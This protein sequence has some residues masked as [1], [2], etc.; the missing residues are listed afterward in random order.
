MRFNTK[1]AA[2]FDQVKAG[3]WL[4]LN[5]LPARHGVPVKAIF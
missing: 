5:A 3:K 1:S 4:D 2:F